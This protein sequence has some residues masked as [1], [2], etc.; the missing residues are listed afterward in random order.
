VTATDGPF[1]VVRHWS[2]WSIEDLSDPDRKQPVFDTEQ[3]AAAEAER[4]NV[5]YAVTWE[6]RGPRTAR[7]VQPGLW[8]GA[9]GGV[10]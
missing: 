2:R 6:P 9:G 5:A 7:P 3:E 1:R 10:A 4:L 8:D